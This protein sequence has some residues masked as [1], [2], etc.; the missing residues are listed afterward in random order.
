MCCVKFAIRGFAQQ[1]G[2]AEARV[3]RSWLRGLGA[4][5]SGAR[6]F[7]SFAPRG[8]CS[9][10]SKVLRPCDLRFA[11]CGGVPQWRAKSGGFATGGMGIARGSQA[12]RR[13]IVPIFG[14]LSFIDVGCWMVD[15]VRWM[16]VAWPSTL[17]S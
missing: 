16:L 2:E 11:S 4:K 17:R 1:V 10:T 14:E 7:L 12:G 8:C 5:W 3:L 6:G 13:W 9:V 15:V